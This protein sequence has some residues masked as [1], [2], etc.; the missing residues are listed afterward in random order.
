MRNLAGLARTTLVQ[1]RSKQGLIKHFLRLLTYSRVIL[2]GYDGEDE[3]SKHPAW[4]K[5]GSILVIRKLQQFVPEW[6]Q[7]V[8][9]YFNILNHELTMDIGS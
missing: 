9:T 8:C 6:N 4:A 1:G 3:K 7:Y 2:F 5:D